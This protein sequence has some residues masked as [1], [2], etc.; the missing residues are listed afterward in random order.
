MGDPDLPAHDHLIGRRQKNNDGPVMA[1]GPF[2]LVY[3]SRAPYIRT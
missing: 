1:T 2:F 3:L